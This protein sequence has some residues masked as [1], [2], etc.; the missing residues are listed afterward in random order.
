M[1]SEIFTIWSTYWRGRK[2]SAP[3][4]FTI[5][6]GQTL[7]GDWK[8]RVYRTA[9]ANSSFFPHTFLPS[10]KNDATSLLA[11]GGISHCCS[12]VYQF[13]RYA[14]NL[15]RSETNAPFHPGIEKFEMVVHLVASRSAAYQRRQETRSP[16][17]KSEA[18]T[19]DLL[20]P[21]ASF[22]TRYCIMTMLLIGFRH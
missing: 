5:A 20:Q 15:E 4:H 9:T 2:I 22:N 12:E 13:T 6:K 8:R 1:N 16:C 10:M 19:S 17:I 21:R 11:N 14:Q 7:S 3:F 18:V